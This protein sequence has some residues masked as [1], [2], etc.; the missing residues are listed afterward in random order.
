MYALAA[1]LWSL[2]I[3]LFR[4][5]GW[6]L[7]VLAIG[8]VCAALVWAAFALSPRSGN[9]HSLVAFVV[10]T[11]LALA[12]LWAGRGTALSLSALLFAVVVGVATGLFHSVRVLMLQALAVAASTAVVFGHA[13]GISTGCALGLLTL[14]TAA[15]SSAT[16]FFL[17]RATSRLGSLDPDTGLPNGAGLTRRMASRM[18]GPSFVVAVV[19]LAGIDDARDALG[20]EVGA[21]L[22]RRAVEDLGQVLPPATF[23][24]RIDGDEL[25]VTAGLD[26]TTEASTSRA[27]REDEA[28]SLA[29]T[30]SSAIAAGCYLVGEIEV[31]LRSHVGIAI[32]PWDGHEVPELVRR[33][34]LSAGRAEETGQ[35]CHLW[36]G[37]GGRMTSTDLS[38]LAD[39]RMAVNRDELF[40]TY[41]PQIAPVSNRVAAVE[42]LVRW[43][44]PRL[45][46]V[47]PGRFLP[48]A[49]RT[50]LVHRLTDWVLDEA[51]DA[52][53]RWRALGF[54]LPVSVNL[55]PTC[56]TNPKVGDRILAALESRALP[57]QCL[58][59]EVTETAVLDL[60]QAVTLLRPLYDRGVRISIDDFGTGYT[61]LAVLPDLPLSELKVDQQ[62]VLRLQNSPAD[63]AIVR[64]VREL[65]LRLGV[66][67]VAEGVETGELFERTQEYGFD[68]LQGYFFSRPLEEVR[69]LAYVRQHE[70]AERASLLAAGMGRRPG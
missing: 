33:A 23:I 51:L 25:V 42:A 60:V 48:L 10:L 26:P 31:V 8:V 35:A 5:H 15:S 12:P 14:I 70:S 59:I 69:L 50:G 55:S 46:V 17:T 65:A 54:D 40:L 57:P 24:G 30:L 47:G 39:L 20:Y 63:D 3:V 27:D 7:V 19:R 21:D 32:A 11:G 36:G 67:A 49:E 58:T 56:L 6:T 34:S 64:T 43:N 61:S 1:V 52:Q 9:E 13:D 28:A 45:G 18:G 53:V 66:H 41:Q 29:A 2:E 44:H 16:V 38:L 22:L 62:F 68:L 37:E 4:P